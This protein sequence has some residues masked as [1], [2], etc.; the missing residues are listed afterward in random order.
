MNKV[1]EA[2]FLATKSIEMMLFFQC[3]TNKEKPTCSWDLLHV[4]EKLLP[5]QFVC[6]IPLTLEIL[7]T[8]ILQFSGCRFLF[9]T[10]SLLSLSLEDIV[11]PFIVTRQAN[12]TIMSK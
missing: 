2:L 10:G 6:D 5:F 4:P 3:K 8:F 9:F 11:R 7:I 1:I 12:K